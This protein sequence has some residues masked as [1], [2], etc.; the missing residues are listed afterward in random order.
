[1]SESGV[2]C[3]AQFQRSAGA[4]LK[5]RAKPGNASPFNPSERL[6]QI[7]P[8]HRQTDSCDRSE[9]GTVDFEGLANL[10]KEPS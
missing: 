2:R 8:D 10:H 4:V 3:S 1:M 5:D 9:V 6:R 7:R